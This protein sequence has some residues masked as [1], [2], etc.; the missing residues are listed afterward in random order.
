MRDW[1]TYQLDI[2][3]NELTCNRRTKD[4]VASRHF[5]MFCLCKG[6]TELSLRTWVENCSE[7]STIRR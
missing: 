5:V 6:A 7:D 4:L 2:T 1:I 3:I